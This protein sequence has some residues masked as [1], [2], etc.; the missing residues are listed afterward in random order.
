MA[1]NIDRRTVARRWALRSAAFLYSLKSRHPCCRSK[2]RVNVTKHCLRRR[3]ACHSFVTNLRPPPKRGRPTDPSPR[4]ATIMKNQDPKTPKRL[5]KQGA[6]SLAARAA[7][8]D[9]Q[10]DTARN[11]ARSAKAR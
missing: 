1:A 6:A 4:V 10:A 11:I 7:E 9:K 3:N 8:A 5:S 2:A